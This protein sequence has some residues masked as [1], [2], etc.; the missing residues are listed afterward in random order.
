MFFSCH[1]FFLVVNFV[2]LKSP[3]FRSTRFLQS[4]SVFQ[5]NTGIISKVHVINGD[6]CTLVVT[7]WTPAMS[8]S[9]L[10][11]GGLKRNEEHVKSL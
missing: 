4:V 2:I 5:Q 1:Y 6:N 3:P 9:E 8:R 7:P 11:S 10:N